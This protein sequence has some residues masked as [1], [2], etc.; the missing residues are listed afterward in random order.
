MVDYFSG[1]VLINQL[2]F[3][4][5]R[6]LH[7]NTPFSGVRYSD[8]ELAKRTGTCFRG[9]DEA[10]NALYSYVGP[11]T[12]IIGH[13]LHQDLSSMRL[14]HKKVIDT[15]ILEQNIAETCRIDTVKVGRVDEEPGNEDGGATLDGTKPEKKPEQRRSGSLTL[16]ALA[17]D[18]L[19]REI[20]IGSHD[21]LE[22]TIATR[23]LCHWY[24]VNVVGKMQPVGSI[25]AKVKAKGR[26]PQLEDP[27]LHDEPSALVGNSDV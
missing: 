2:V 24:M 14:I 3:P 4:K 27:P 21:A 26:Q 5:V 20:Q 19:G 9:R 16:K 23:D 17:R 12:I 15:L 7:Y 10:R 8:L 1:Q 11:E 13:A 25:E 22:D 6:M 18:R